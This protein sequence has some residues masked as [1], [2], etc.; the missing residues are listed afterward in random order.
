MNA[1]SNK[2]SFNQ[3]PGHQNRGAR[4]AALEQRHQARAFLVIAL[5]VLLAIS[6]FLWLHNSPAFAQVS[7]ADKP[8]AGATPGGTDSGASSDAE[9]WRQV[10]HGATGTVVGQDKSAGMLIQSDG[11]QWRLVIAPYEAIVPRAAAGL[12]GFRVEVVVQWTERGLAR[13]VRL[14]TVRFARAAAGL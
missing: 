12:L 5:T 1:M 11:Q 2:A 4:S 6:A 7:G 8:V 14:Q 10:R 3:N 13:Q 9:I